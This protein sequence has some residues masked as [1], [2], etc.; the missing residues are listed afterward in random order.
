MRQKEGPL[1]CCNSVP[2]TLPSRWEKN[3]GEEHKTRLLAK[4]VAKHEKFV[5]TK[6]MPLVLFLVTWWNRAN[7]LLASLGYEITHKILLINK[8]STSKLS[9]KKKRTILY[10]YSSSPKDCFQEYL[11]LE[12]L[13]F[14]LQDV[15]IV[16]M[17]RWRIWFRPVINHQYHSFFWSPSCKSPLD[18]RQHMR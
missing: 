14:D 6:A 9:L 15:G 18:G 3:A 13:F 17:D 11:Y 1:D 12:V 10:E 8:P 4:K 16:W 2:L 5:M 7:T